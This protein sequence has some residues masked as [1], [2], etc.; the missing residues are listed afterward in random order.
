M[1]LYMIGLG[2]NDEKDISLKGLEAVKKCKTIYLEKYTSILHCDIKKLEELY[3]KKVIIADRDMVESKAEDTILKD[4]EMDDTAFLVVG[5]VFGATTHTDLMIRAKKDSIEVKVINNASILNAVGIT[6]LELYKF[7]KTTSIVFPQE[8]WMP[9]TPYDVLREN[10]KMNLHTLCLLDI[11]VAEPS[12][13][14][15][16]KGINKIQKPRFMRINEAIDYMIDIEQMQGENI[17]TSETLCIGC[18]R[19][20]SENPTII[21]GKAKELIE[22]D[23]GEPLHCLIIPAKLHFIEE[24]ALKFW[25]TL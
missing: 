20:S 8:N 10:Q 14:D 13:E 24:E 9:H 21:S 16:K 17:F 6:G 11:K 15:L 7:G 19:L 1:T 22:T 5:D 2:L 3:G 12:S 4:A 25:K 18:A 23:F